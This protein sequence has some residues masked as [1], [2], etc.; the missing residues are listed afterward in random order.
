MKTYNFNFIDK[1]IYNK[2]EKNK[3][4][5]S[6]YNKGKKSYYLLLPPPN[7]TGDLHIGHLLP[8]TILDIYARIK[9]MKGYNVCWIPGTDHASI[10]T[11]IKIIKIL[12]NN[13]INNLK[14]NKL[15]LLIFKWAKKY[16][17]IIIDQLKKM[18][19]SCDW[20]KF[21]FTMDKNYYN[22]VIKIFIK[23]YNK[24]LIYKRN[25]IL[26]WDIIAKTTISDEEVIYK[27]RTNYLYYIKYFTEDKKKYLPI[28]TTRPETIFG[29]TAVCINPT[30]KRYKKKILKL[31]V[32]IVN[33]IIPVIYDKSVNKKIGTG[34]LKITPAHSKKDFKIFKKNKN[35][36]KIINIFNE[37]G[38]LNKVSKNYEGMD[39]FKVREKIYKKLKKLGYLIKK[40]KVINKIGYSDRT[41]TIIEKKISLEWFL[42][43]KKFIKPTL[44]FIK[45]IKIFPNNKYINLFYKWIK[46]LKDWN[47]SRRLIWGHKIPIYYYYYNEKRISIAANSLTEAI[48]ILRHKYPR[49]RINK[50]K[51][52]Q[53]THVL[54]TWFSSWMLPIAALKIFIKNN[55]FKYYFPIDLLVTGYD[56]LFFWVLRMIM[57]STFYIKRIPFKTIYFTGIARDK[58]KIKLSK[59][60]GNYTNLYKLLKKYGADALRVGILVNNHKRDFI[61]SEDKN[62]IKGRNFINKIWNSYKLILKI[63]NIK[64]NKKKEKG[65]LL[66]IKWFYNILNY[67]LYKLNILLKNYKINKSLN[68]IK[69]IFKDKFCSIYLE[70][71]KPNNN[72]INKLVKKFTLNYYKILLKILHPYIPF[73][74][75]YLWSR[76]NNT[77]KDIVNTS[78]PKI[79]GFNKDIIKKFNNTLN[80]IKELK[81]IKVKKEK[82]ILFIDK[83]DSKII[84]KKIYINLL[85]KYSYIKSIKIKKQNKYWFLFLN[86]YNFFILK[87]DIY[88]D[89]K[90]NRKKIL[91]KIKFYK[92]YLFNI[93][94]QLNNKKFLLNAPKDIIELEKKKVKDI[95]EKILNL[96][97]TLFNLN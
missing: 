36:I 32:P 84:L 9:R 59:S 6:N 74:T 29:D 23:L 44:K 42:K 56:I 83:K 96:K 15:K 30:D 34:C 37:D 10:A 75:E 11:E 45:K 63:N 13:G 58:N 46:N 66:I 3:Y 67:N 80:L 76:L 4:F 55:N 73:I 85:Y 72:T 17:K 62:C 97:K 1:F 93:K 14:K 78:W 25:K 70:F 48:K 27:H 43:I 35:K 65:E 69:K 28:A 31:I 81:K 22:F 90:N 95:I 51:I 52:K 89:K 47:I 88:L 79:K 60:L 50:K 12:K 21:L 71:I 20:T 53:D 87:K 5:Y 8:F 40:K 54:D 39:R 92:K 26:N 49:N 18:G 68:L 7:I 91:K 61:F 16:N 86:K 38:T 77:K 2:W 24:G 41:N 82:I 57:F 94:K 64:K 19:C 33:R